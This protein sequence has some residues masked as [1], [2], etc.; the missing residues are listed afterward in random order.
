MAKVNA[1]K[2][3]IKKIQFRIHSRNHESSRIGAVSPF[4]KKKVEII[5]DEQQQ[6][7]VHVYKTPASRHVRFAAVSKLQFGSG[8]AHDT[9]QK[10][11]LQDDAKKIAE[12]EIKTDVFAKE[13][14]ETDGFDLTERS[15]RAVKVSSQVTFIYYIV[16]TFCMYL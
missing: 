4:P 10:S 5:P 16:L 2:K 1:E 11:F 12:D 15:G 8:R 9:I 3:M 7:T 13:E 14:I 6:R